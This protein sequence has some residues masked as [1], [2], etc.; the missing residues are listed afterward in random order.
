MRH[1]E[2]EKKAFKRKDLRESRFLKKK[3]SI[4]IAERKDTS[5]ENTVFLKL[6]IQSPITLE[7]REAERLN[8]SPSLIDRERPLAAGILIKLFLPWS[9]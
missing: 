6:I 5:R 1:S 8:K 4:L 9:D 2:N 7:K 3:E